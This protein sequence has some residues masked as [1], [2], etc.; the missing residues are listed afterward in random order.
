MKSG[1]VRAICFDLDNTLWDVEPVLARAER[2]LADWLAA[3]YPKI[4]E[5]YSSEDF[6]AMRQALLLERPDMAHDFTFL[7]RETLARLAESVGYDR[8]LAHEAF[9]AWH[10]ARNQCVPFVEVLPALGKLGQRFRLATLSN[11]NADLGTIG[12]AHHFEVTLH[13]AA[14]GC[15]KPDARAYLALADALTLEPG[16]ILFVGDDPHADVV[17]PRNAG[18][19]TAW[20]N[21][22]A[23]AWP[24]DLHPAD[25]VVA[26]LE[27]LVAL[28][29]AKL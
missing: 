3:R 1:P 19:R 25:H 7:R 21:R 15:A 24:A 28:A 29:H 23:G 13:A 5:R 27:E 11:G 6:F 9:A 14:L 10:A 17:G 16:E 20:M 4:P 12:I 18:M 22:G 8:G 26:D 2:I